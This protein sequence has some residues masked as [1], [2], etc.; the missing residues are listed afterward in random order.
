LL[1]RLPPKGRVGDTAHKQTAKSER[2]DLAFSRRSATRAERLASTVVDVLEVEEDD[3]AA[4]RH[5]GQER[6]AA[7][8]YCAQG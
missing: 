1:G 6:C 2:V 7:C 5:E 3:D 4:G 8:G